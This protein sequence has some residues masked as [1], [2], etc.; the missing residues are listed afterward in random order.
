[1]GSQ[2]EDICTEW[3]LKGSCCIAGCHFD[4]WPI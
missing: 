1:M 3:A 4:Y 2:I